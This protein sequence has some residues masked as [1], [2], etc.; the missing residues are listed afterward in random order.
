MLKCPVIVGVKVEKGGSRR[1]KFGCSANRASLSA[2]I[3][4]T[5]ALSIP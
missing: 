4:L 2:L 5:D 1:L 3:G